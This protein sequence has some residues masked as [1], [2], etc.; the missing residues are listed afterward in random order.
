MWS[1]LE[2]VPLRLPTPPSP[3]TPEQLKRVERLRTLL[4]NEPQALDVSS[5]KTGLS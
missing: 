2:L 5:L 1:Y 4:N 3:H